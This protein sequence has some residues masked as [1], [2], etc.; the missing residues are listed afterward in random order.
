MTIPAI[1]PPERPVLVLSALVVVRVTLAP[2]ATG[3]SKGT[4]VVGLDVAVTTTRVLEVGRSGAPAV[5][6]CVL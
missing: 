6:V 1:A 4:V 3:A 5:C 2:V